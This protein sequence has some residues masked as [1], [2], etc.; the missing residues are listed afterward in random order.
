MASMSNPGDRKADLLGRSATQKYVGFIRSPHRLALSKIFPVHCW[1]YHYSDKNMV[2]EQAR[3]YCQKKYTDLVAI[4][5]KQEIEYL[6]KNIPFNPTYY[7][8]GI[9]KVN[10]WWTW[11][12]TNKT[13]TTEAE[14]WGRGEPNN[15]KN[16]EDCVEIYI[17][18]AKDSGKWN[19]DACTKAKRALCYTASC[20]STLCSGHGECIETINNYTCSCDEGFYGS[21]CQYAVQ[22][23]SLAAHPHG[24]ISCFHPW[25]DFSFQSSCRFQCAEGFLLN[26]TDESKCLSSGSWSSRAPH[27]TATKCEALIAPHHSL[28]ECNHP[29]ADYSYGSAC[30]FTCAEGWR[31]EGYNVTECGASGHWTQNT[32]ACKVVHCAPLQATEF[33]SMDCSHGVFGN[34]SFETVCE[35]GCDEGWIFGAPN[36]TVC[37]ASGEWSHSVIQCQG[38]RTF[39]YPEQ[40][41]LKAVIVIGG[42]TAGSALT[43]ALAVWLISRQLKKEFLP[44]S[45]PAALDQDSP[46]LDLLSPLASSLSGSSAHDDEVG[47][48]SQSQPRGHHMGLAAS[49]GGYVSVSPIQEGSGVEDTL[50]QA[51]IKNLHCSSDTDRRPTKSTQHR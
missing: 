19:D 20:N 50:I 43:L 15:K 34:F 31:L 32:P 22:C 41:H 10:G 24:N 28:M 23:Q 26:G 45:E 38:Q 47:V 13:L 6:E 11:V 21:H 17:K 7:W 2:Y 1:T 37:Q 4:Q 9:R 44:P 36:K 51:P 42:A 18:R 3:I 39:Q 29:W 49:Q 48:Q 40:N 30:M 46:D 25:G 16:T 35:F 33:D 8:I 27:C 14:N 12:G 5:N